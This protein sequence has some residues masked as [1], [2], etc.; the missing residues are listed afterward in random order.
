MLAGHVF[1]D[2][3]CGSG[4]FLNLAYAMIRDIETDII[5]EVRRRQEVTDISLDVTLD[6][7]VTIDQFH[8]FEINWWPARIAETAMFLVDH[9][10]NRKLA[11]EIGDAPDRLPIT[12]TAHIHHIN[13]LTHD[14]SSLLPTPVGMTYLF[15]NPPFL[16]H[17]TRTPEQ[18]ADL[19][20]AWQRNDIGRLDYVTAWHAKTLDLLTSRPGEFA[21]V[22]TN[23]IA[24]GD[25]V[26]RLFGPIFM[27]G[28][29]IK[30]AHRTFAWTSEAPGQAS[31]HCVIVGF[32]KNETGR[33]RLWDYDS[34][35]AAPAPVV[36]TTGINAYLIDGPNVLVTTRSRP[37]NAELPPV[38]FGSTPRDGGHMIV[39]ASDFDMVAADPAAA[40]YLRPFRG[41][42]ELLYNQQR[43][44]LWLVD[45]DPADVTKS[46][47]LKERLAGV[48]RFRENSTSPDARAAAATPHLFWWRS[49]PDVPYL[50]IP[51]V[52]SETRRYFTAARLPADTI[53]SNLLYTAPDPDG[54]LFAVVS[55]SMFIAW[56]RAVGGRLES[57]CASPGH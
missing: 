23:S 37:L 34:P 36:V 21:Y 41:A 1:V 6:T 53:A 4:N 27:A 3:A 25:Q 30:F 47:I 2:P 12:I 43:W 51:G 9:Q 24:Q 32:T 38:S 7:K 33:G 22:A 19:R 26:P 17:D 16:G 55:S 29:R 56:Q 15:G 28:W 44:C 42:R 50:A 39:E 35:K 48:R 8:G 40:K 45:L 13:A 5:V 52:V 54:L 11:L 31:V 49:Q 10:A 20:T 14:W 18:A 46:T 57:V